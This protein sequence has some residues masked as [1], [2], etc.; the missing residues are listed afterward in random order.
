MSVE[1]AETGLTTNRRLR[2]FDAALED[3]DTIRMVV[4]DAD[5]GKVCAAL[6]G[7]GAVEDAERLA[8]E[9]GFE[10]DVREDAQ[11]GRRAFFETD[12]PEF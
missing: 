4:S 2:N 3:C 9:Y 7:G 10:M 8:S 12:Y 1:N 6:W 5:T 11:Y